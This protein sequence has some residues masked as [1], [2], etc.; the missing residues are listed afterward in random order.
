MDSR[1]VEVRR[2]LVPD[3][4]LRALIKHCGNI[5]CELCSALRE[6]LAFRKAARRLKRDGG[7][8]PGSPLQ[9][10]ALHGVLDV[11]REGR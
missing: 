7:A 2:K 10:W 3:A 11:L 9:Q 4:V 5:E 8:F 6:L 1:K